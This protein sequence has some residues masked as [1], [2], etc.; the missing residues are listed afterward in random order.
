MCAYS[1]T[2]YY[3]LNH[4]FYVTLLQLPQQLL[5][6]LTPVFTILSDFSEPEL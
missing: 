1:W 5:Q 4:N 6:E 3:L 2:S